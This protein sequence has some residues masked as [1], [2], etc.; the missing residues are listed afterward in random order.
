MKDIVAANQSAFI[1]GRSL[2]DNFLLVRQ[3]ARKI[4]ARRDP[5]VFLKLD[6]SRTL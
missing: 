6:I 3:V 1:L 4:H 2:H 5:G